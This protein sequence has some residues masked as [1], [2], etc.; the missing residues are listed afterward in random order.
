MNKILLCAVMG[1]LVLGG[2]QPKEE[3]N[4]QTDPSAGI[5]SQRKEAARKLTAQSVV[6]LGQKDYQGAVG[7]LDAA[8]KADPTDQD[9]YLI[10]GQILLKAGEFQRAADFLDAAVKNFPDNGMIFYMLSIA[11]Q[12]SGKKLPAVLAARR[13]FEIFKDANDQDN[14]QKS[15]LLLQQIINAPE[16]SSGTMEKPVMPAANA[17]RK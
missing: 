9:P 6:L 16:G 11:N 5:T 7:S 14:A 13:S 17:V 1:L 3:S 4:N 12:M 2:C 8:I 10:L 15:A